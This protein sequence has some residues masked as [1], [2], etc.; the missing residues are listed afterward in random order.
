MYHLYRSHID[1][2]YKRRYNIISMT[3]Y[4]IFFEGCIYDIYIYTGENRSWNKKTQTAIRKMRL[5]KRN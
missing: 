5:K 2:E 3:V 1:H 4:T